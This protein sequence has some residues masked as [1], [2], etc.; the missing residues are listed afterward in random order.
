M[1]CHAGMNWRKQALVDFILELAFINHQTTEEVFLHPDPAWYVSSIDGTQMVIKISDLQPLGHPI[2]QSLS[3]KKHL[4][5]YAPGCFQD[6]F[7]IERS[8]VI[9]C[10]AKTSS[11]KEPS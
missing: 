10:D 4:K 2:L 6:H 11:Q 5:E 7:F 1:T 8:S 9:P 3:D